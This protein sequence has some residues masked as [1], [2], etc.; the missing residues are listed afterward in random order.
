M[1]AILISVILGAMRIAGHTSIPFQAIAHCWVGYL[2]GAWIVGI[3]IDKAVDYWRP[4]EETLEGQIKTDV[5]RVVRT[6]NRCGWLALG[7]TILEVA[8]AVWFRHFAE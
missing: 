7:L 8:C 1:I 6:C 2:I 3:A 4:H 5:M